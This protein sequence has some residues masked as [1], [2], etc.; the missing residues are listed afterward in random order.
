MKYFLHVALAWGALYV[1]WLKVATLAVAA[2]ESGEVALEKEESNF[3]LLR[4]AWKES[5][6]GNDA[7]SLPP[8]DHNA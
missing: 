8:A 5:R 2:T 4:R 6:N 1:F 7:S 3:S